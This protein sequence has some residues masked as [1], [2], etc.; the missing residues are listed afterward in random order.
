MQNRKNYPA[1]IQSLQ[2]SLRGEPDDQVGWVRLGEAY[3]RAGRHAAAIKA[4][5]HAKTLRPDDWVCS[6]LIA[7]VQ[8][9]TGQFTEAITSLKS[10]LD[11]H[12]S[13][14]GVLIALSTAHL[15]NGAQEVSSGFFARAEVS[16]LTAIEV[17]WKAMETN[18][19]FSRVAWKIVADSLFRYSGI[20]SPRETQRL[21]DAL[22]T[23]KEILEAAPSI[24]IS[25]PL[26]D[27]FSPE[28]VSALN[29][30]E[31]AIATYE[32]RISFGFY[33]D[34]AK[35]SAWYDFGVA[36]QTLRSRNVA[37]HATIT[38]DQAIRCLK[39]AASAEPDEELHWIALGDAY[40]LKNAK[41][42][43]HAYIRSL[44][45]NSKVSVISLRRNVC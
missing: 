8:S 22:I 19:G 43:Q 44:E 38:Q 2:I 27:S 17:A 31:F 23:L 33:D 4:L 39:E 24:P 26:V 32:Y 30:L 12:P 15:N 21:T 41:S 3:A 5:E 29:T 16:F 7:D 6:Y 20:Q 34:K 42:A 11:E 37:S 35:A 45:L 13:E 36:L 28:A 25:K 1:A 14:L 40:F 10:I 18:S 9:Q